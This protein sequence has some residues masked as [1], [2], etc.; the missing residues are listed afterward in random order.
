ML[1]DLHFVSQAY[2]HHRR[3]KVTDLLPRQSPLFSAAV[4]FPSP[5]RFVIDS[6]SKQLFVVFW[7]PPWMLPM[8]EW[9]PA[10]PY[11]IS[12]F[13]LSFSLGRIC[14][15]YQKYSDPFFSLFRPSLLKSSQMS[16][17]VTA[18]LCFTCPGKMEETVSCGV[19]TTWGV[20]LT[21][22]P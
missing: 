9:A 21:G 13:I 22:T 2:N 8:T 19:T 14:L 18:W 5:L 16:D 12:C 6:S 7:Y 4:P 3:Q 1:H 17:S 20:G 15:A 11:V 10:M